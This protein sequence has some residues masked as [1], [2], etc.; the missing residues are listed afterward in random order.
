MKMK[1]TRRTAAILILLMTAVLII[2]F[3]CSAKEHEEVP[4]YD[5]DFDA[6]DLGGLSI[7]WGFSMTVYTEDTDN[8]FGFIPGTVFADTANERKKQ[9]ENDLN[10]KISVFND[11]NSSVI[12]DR[13]NAAIVSGAHL[14]DIATADSSAMS[15]FARTG[16]LTGLSSLLDVQNTDKWGT[17]N[18][19]MPVLWKT[20]LYG[21]VP[22][23]WPNLLYS[24]AGHV[25][26]V[27]ENMI[28][29]LG[30]TDPRE[31]AEALTWTWDKFEE[32]LQRYTYQESDRTVYAFQSHPAYFAMNMFL[33]NGVSMLAFQDGKVVNGLYTD[34]GKEA[35]ERSQSI[36]L[37]NCRDYIHPSDTTASGELLANGECVMISQGHGGMIQTSGS[38]MYVVDNVGILPFPQ[39]PKAT[40]GVYPSYYQ[41]I[42]YITS[43]PITANDAEAAASVLRVMYEPFE[44]LE[45]KDDIAN[46]MNK[47]IFFDD[48]DA[49]IFINM[50]EHTEYNYFWEGGRS[51]VESTLSSKNPV[52][53]VLESYE[54]N[55]E[56]LVEEY[57][58]PQYLGRLAVYGK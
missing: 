6:S 53:T 21:V 45:T 27:N 57:I 49:Y 10:C 56:K 55:Y 7:Q 17:P 18:M 23:A 25:I 5:T 37:Y 54:S 31:Y 47:E 22:F 35:L 58:Y 41:Q 3:A 20:D 40:P 11:S 14:Y 29:R 28:S 8:V 26:A 16:A 43:I 13:L 46:Y 51:G 50:V 44:G 39:G 4:E 48:R 24:F 1:S 15:S 52:S 9:V 19:L 36:Y 38:I 34:A 12:R 33:S 30:E 42:P 32:C 2:L